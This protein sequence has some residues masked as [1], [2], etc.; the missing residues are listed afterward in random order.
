MRPQICMPHVRLSC[1]SSTI[2]PFFNEYSQTRANTRGSIPC[3]SSDPPWLVC[4]KSNREP[5]PLAEATSP[6]SALMHHGPSSTHFGDL[7][8][9]LV[10]TQSPIVFEL[11]E[12]VVVFALRT[13]PPTVRWIVL[14]GAIPTPMSSRDAARTG[15]SSVIAGEWWP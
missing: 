15:V 4:S 1:F 10:R 8:P 7:I 5:Q 11:V 2:A 6:I 14:I 9:G 13:L 3:L 12:H